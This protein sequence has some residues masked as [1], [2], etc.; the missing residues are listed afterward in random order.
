MFLKDNVDEL[1]LTLNFHHD[2]V[3]YVIYETT[4]V[5]KRYGCGERGHLVR[6]C[7]KKGNDRNGLI[8][9]TENGQNEVAAVAAEM[10][11]QSTALVDPENLME[12]SEETGK[13]IQKLL[14]VKIKKLKYPLE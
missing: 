5:I 3:N 8:V 7:P 1:D 10:P 12:S 13:Y 9:V 6:V 2:Y 4:N 14:Q 11:G